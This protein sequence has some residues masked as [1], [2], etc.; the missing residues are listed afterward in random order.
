MFC[1]FQL[2]E[3]L[4]ARASSV[5][6]RTG[7]HLFLCDADNGKPPLLLQMSSDSDDLKFMYVIIKVLSILNHNLST[8][9][10]K[11]CLLSQ[12]YCRSALESFKKRVAYANARFD[13]ILVLICFNFKRNDFWIYKFKL[14]INW[15]WMVKFYL[16]QLF[17]TV[18][19]DLNTAHRYR[20]VEFIIIASCIWASKS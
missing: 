3:K 2:M 1:G 8:I 12:L 9:A 19:R 11:W 13:C 4:A 20:R 10:V 17:H 15:S 14:V 6:G 7:K 16:L 5:L 18:V